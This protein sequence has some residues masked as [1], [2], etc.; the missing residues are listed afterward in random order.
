MAN[1]LVIRHRTDEWF[2][3]VR[4][5]I[6]VIAHHKNGILGHFNFAHIVKTF[7]VNVTFFY[8]FAIK[9]YN[10]ILNRDGIPTYSNN[11]LNALQTVRISDNYD[12]PM[13]QSIYLFGSFFS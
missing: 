4:R 7:F 9:K 10:A 8:R 11:A 2:S 13:L 3:A 6:A 1:D 5:M 12:I